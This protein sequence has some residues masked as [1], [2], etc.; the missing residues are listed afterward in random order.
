VRGAL[1]DAGREFGM[2]EV[3]SKAYSTSSVESGWV[4]TP[5]PAIFSAERMKAYREWLPARSFEGFASLGGSFVSDNI[6]DYYFTPWDLDYGRHIKFDHEFI[7]RAALE[8]MA[9]RRHRHKV[10]LVWSKED[11]LE[12]FGGMM[13]E[14]DMPKF[15]D[16]PNA[17]YAGFCFDRV[18]SGGRDVGVSII[19][20]YSANQRAWISLAT[21]HEEF[22]DPGTSVSVIWGEPDA[23]ERKM[24][25]R[26]SIE[27][28]RQ[29]EVRAT[30]QPWP[31]NQVNRETYRART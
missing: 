8:R 22:A 10:T 13:E 20:V 11:V 27:R 21:V 25:V 3:G 5:M 9:T 19:P 12:V 23:R 2:L 15:M 4:P 28:H 31:I 30:V 1:E 16:M 24:S 17:Y 14:G 18:L 29:I 6:E 7:G 26:P